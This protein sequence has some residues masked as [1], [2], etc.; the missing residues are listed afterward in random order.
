LLVDG[1]WKLAGVQAID[2]FRWSAEIELVATF[3]RQVAR[4]RRA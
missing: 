4:R 2:Q 3:R 1:G